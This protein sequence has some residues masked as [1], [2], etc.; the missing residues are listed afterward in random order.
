MELRGITI[1]YDDL[2]GRVVLAIEPLRELLD[3]LSLTSPAI[4]TDIEP[5]AQLELPL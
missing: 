5:F 3:K 4:E 1:D 2:W